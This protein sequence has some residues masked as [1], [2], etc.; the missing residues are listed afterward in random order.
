M[1]CSD[2]GMRAKKTTTVE[3]AVVISKDGVIL[4]MLLFIHHAEMFVVGFLA[5]EKVGLQ[6]YMEYN[7]CCYNKK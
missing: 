6:C 3:G 4:D 1:S 5:N 7:Y 2:A